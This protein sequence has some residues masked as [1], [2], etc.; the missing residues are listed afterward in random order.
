MR[1]QFAVRQGCQAADNILHL[2]RDQSPNDFHWADK[3]VVVSLGHGRT[4]AK[5][6]GFHFSGPLATIAYKS[7]YLM[8]TIGARAKLQAILEWGM[9]MFLPRDVSEL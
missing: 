2:M 1:A 5:I 9:N 7:I 3:G 8:S 6:V 4:Y